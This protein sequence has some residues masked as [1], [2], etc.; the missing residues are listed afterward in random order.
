MGTWLPKII[1]QRTNGAS[2]VAAL[3]CFQCVGNDVEA[4]CTVFNLFTM[5]SDCSTTWKVSQFLPS[6]VQDTQARDPLWNVN[7]E[8]PS[9]SVAATS[10]GAST[11]AGAQP[12]LARPHP[13]R[14]LPTKPSAPRHSPHLPHR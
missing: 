14:H 5:I 11:S 7:A 9:L 12:H 4:L 8:H 3:N 1:A 10:V 13:L 6:P 2:P